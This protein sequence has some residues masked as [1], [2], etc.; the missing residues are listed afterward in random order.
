MQRDLQ[1]N[2]V[3]DLATTLTLVPVAQS[4]FA[5]LPEWVQKQLAVEAGIT[6]WYSQPAQQWGFHISANPRTICAIIAA[7]ALA[8]AIGIV[9]GPEVL[10]LLQ[11]FGA[12]LAGGMAAL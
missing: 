8:V 10:P 9:L 6:E 2:C 11:E 4:Q 1:V 5:A 7:V 3:V 12:T